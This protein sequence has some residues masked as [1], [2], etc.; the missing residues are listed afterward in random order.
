MAGATIFSEENETLDASTPTT[1]A[2]TRE[3]SKYLS[4]LV[5]KRDRYHIFACDQC[6]KAKSACSVRSPKAL[7]DADSMPNIRNIIQQSIVR[8]TVARSTASI[9]AASAAVQN[10]RSVE[11]HDILR[12]PKTQVDSAEI[13]FAVRQIESTR[14]RRQMET[15]V[16][17]LSI[18][19]ETWMK[20]LL[21]EKIGRSS[22]FLC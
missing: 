2:A 13:T 4:H 16:V 6:A 9:L 18:V 14:R 3:E 7:T 17:C 12:P 20:V 10:A 5:L 22:P 15:L 1:L 21:K 19:Q 11:L 8:V